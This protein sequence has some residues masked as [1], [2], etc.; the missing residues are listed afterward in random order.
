MGLGSGAVMGG[1]DGYTVSASWLTGLATSGLPMTSSVS[2]VLPA[3]DRDQM[4]MVQSMPSDRSPMV[5]AVPTAT[6]QWSKAPEPP[7]DA[8][9]T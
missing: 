1:S 8:L 6:Y 7:A 5:H 3:A 2:R 9:M 4:S